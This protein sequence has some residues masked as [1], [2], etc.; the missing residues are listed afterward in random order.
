MHTFSPNTLAESSKVN[1]N[2]TDLSTGDAD[3][4]DN[5]LRL[6]RSE[7]VSDFVQSGLLW[8]T[9][10]GLDA[11]MSSGVA[12]ITDATPLMLRIEVSAVTTR[13]FTASKDTYVDLGYDG[14]LDYNEVVNG[15]TPPTL[16]SYHIRLA[17]VITS[18]VAVTSITTTGY[19]AT[20]GTAVPFKNS[21][22]IHVSKITNPYKF[23]A[24]RNSAFNWGNNAAAKV[25]FDTEIFDTNNDFASG[26]YT[27]PVNGFYH[28][29]SEVAG[30]TISGAG[31]YIALYVN[32]SQ[33]ILGD[34]GVPVGYTGAFATRL[35]V[36]GV[37]QLSATDTVD[38]YVYGGN[39]TGATGSISSYFGGFLLSET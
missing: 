15:A 29:Y 28:F 9:I 17:K 22:P 6:F 7:I 4:E 14:V 18:G 26:T 19:D 38:V 20:A 13:A 35:G 33:K 39:N 8:S 2:F 37:I 11:G 5:S 31:V 23:H 25:T 34:G 36:S 10:S 32:G 24:Y 30:Q 27:A 16:A 12:Y 3:T 1:D 21:K